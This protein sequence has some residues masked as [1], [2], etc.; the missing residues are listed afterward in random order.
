MN[1]I[2]TPN[3]NVTNLNWSNTR[4]YKMINE[5]AID[6]FS[7]IQNERQNFDFFS[8]IFIYNF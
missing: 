4:C 8:K 3:Y 6:V 5:S 2:N 7:E 1:D